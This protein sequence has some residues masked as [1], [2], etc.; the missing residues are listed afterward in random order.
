[1]KCCWWPKWVAERD[2]GSAR[3]FDMTL[4]K[5]KRCGTPWMNVF[6]VAASTGGFEPVKPADVEAIRAIKDPQELKQFMRS[7]VEYLA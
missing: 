4:G 7:W 3:G 2:V 5:C 1:M 6:C